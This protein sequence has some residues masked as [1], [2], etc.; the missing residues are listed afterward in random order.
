[1]ELEICKIHTTK[2]K[3]HSVDKLFKSF[4]FEPIVPY[5]LWFEHELYSIV[6]VADDKLQC[7]RHRYFNNYKLTPSITD[8]D[9]NIEGIKIFLNEMSLFQP[10]YPET[11]FYVYE[12]LKST[13]FN[14]DCK[15]V[16]HIGLNYTFGTMEAIMI[17]DE[18]NSRCN[19][20]HLVRIGNEKFTEN[21]V[22]FNNDK[23]KF[24]NQPYKVIYFETKNDL[25][26]TY[27]F[28]SIDCIHFL[29]SSFEWNN[30]EKDFQA[31]LYYLLLA[32]KN[33]YKG[34]SLIIKMRL[35]ATPKWQLIVDIVKQS[36][37]TFNFFRSSIMH[38]HNN[39]IYLYAENYLKKCKDV[40][41]GNS[42]ELGIYKK[43]G[44]KYETT[45]VIEKVIPLKKF[46]IN[47]WFEYHNLKQI[48]TIKSNF[49]FKAFVSDNMVDMKMKMNDG[50]CA[51]Q[52]TCTLNHFKRVMDTKSISEWG[53]LMSEINPS[54]PLKHMIKQKYKL[55]HVSNAWLKLY[56][57]FNL[58]PD[59]IT[60]KKINSFHICEAPGAFI[61]ATNHYVG[62]K[63]VNWYA[64][65]LKP[66]KDNTALDDYFNLIRDFP[67]RWLFGD[68]D[69]EEWEVGDS[70]DI[71]NSETIEYY[72][73]HEKLKDI[74]F[75]TADGG[76]HCEQYDLNYQEELTEFIFSSE[77]ECILRCL[78]KNGSAIIKC[79]LP[80]NRTTTRCSIY[81]LIKQFSKVY[82]VKP[83]TS[84]STNSE[85]YIVCINYKKTNYKKY[86]SMSET[87]LMP[88]Q[89][90]NI[91]CKLIENQINALLNVYYCYYNEEEK[92][93]QKHK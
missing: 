44:L 40:K 88:E 58:I 37:K 50:E 70:G 68:E 20:Y 32:I 18:M 15:N 30:E 91:I 12:F 47:E 11:F 82:I 29:N 74:D 19:N 81:A 31:T 9:N 51:K 48:N 73:K 53:R 79:Y 49:K 78:A 83:K 71:V 41:F 66:S 26:G 80:A 23:I 72:E 77:V 6:V 13:A 63:N 54:I 21:N 56:E 8:K 17:Y 36:F 92:E 16:L 42:Y 25:W 33:M 4:E 64:Q 28:I 87:D 34:A 27:T 89:Y 60:K 57:I 35:N 52:L 39:D 67:D 43:H 38:K 24:L 22:I 3:I 46:K 10:Y 62:V 7:N 2:Y 69:K 75:M 5:N 76:I 1:M 14:L 86:I 55:P 45:E 90:E 61:M 84:N 85:I 65:T 93:K 59:I